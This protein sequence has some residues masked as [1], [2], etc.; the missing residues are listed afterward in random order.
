MSNQGININVDTSSLVNTAQGIQTEIGNIKKYWNI[1]NETLNNKNYWQ[2]SAS[3]LHQKSFNK[4]KDDLDKII[5]RLS[6]HPENLYQ[7]AGIYEKDEEEAVS[8][9]T[10]LPNELIK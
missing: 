4:M 5:K 9:I 10:E 3:N 7:I 1:I 2:G 6:N 8:I